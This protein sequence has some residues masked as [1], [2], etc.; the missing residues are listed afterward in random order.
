MAY[1]QFIVPTD[2]DF[3]TSLGV[4]PEARGEDGVRGIVIPA[5]DGFE[6]D[7][8]IDPLGLSV[9]LSV[10]RNTSEIMRIIREGATALRLAPTSPE[11][12]IEFTTDDTAGRIEV[13]L[14]PFIYVA[15]TTLLG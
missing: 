4:I 9:V 15:E 14:R 11:I 10:T 6:V 5:T 12:V 2:H 1:R 7:L 8:T 3:V 13:T